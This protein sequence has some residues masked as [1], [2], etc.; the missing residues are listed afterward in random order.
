MKFKLSRVIVVLLVAVMA[1]R[2]GG[3]L[4]VAGYAV[5]ILVA[6]EF[7]IGIAAILSGLPISLAVAHNWLAGLLLLALLRIVALNRAF[8][9]NI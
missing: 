5:L 7:S 9:E 8:T 4:R 6:L 1:Y 2:A 3:K